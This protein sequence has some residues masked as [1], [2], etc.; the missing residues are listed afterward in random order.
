MKSTNRLLLTVLLLWLALPLMADGS[1]LTAPSGTSA[2]YVGLQGGV[3]FGV[4][5]FSAFGHDQTHAGFVGGIYGGYRFHPVVSLEAF[6]K[7][8][9]MA[10]TAQ[11]CCVDNHLWLG[12]DGNRYNVP[13]L[14]MDG[15]HYSDLHSQ[16]F[17]QHYG[18]QLNINLLGCFPTTRDSRWTLELS[19]LLAAVGTKA[20]VSNKADEATVIAGSQQW[21][22]GTGGN[23][24]VSYQASKHI[25]VGIYSGITYLTGK[26]FDGMPDCPHRA[27]YIW[28]SGVRLAF[29]MPTNAATERR[30]APLQNI[31]P[32]VEPAAERIAE[33]SLSPTVETPF[34]RVSASEAS[35]TSD[36]AVETPFMASPDTALAQ[37]THIKGVSTSE[38]TVAP[39]SDTTILSSPAASE[40]SGSEFSVQRSAHSI[41][42]TFNSTRI[43][44]S[45]LST[46]EAIRDT[47]LADP[48]LH[49]VVEGYCDAEGTTD[50][51]TNISTFR[52]QAVKDCLVSWG[53]SPERITVIGKGTDTQAPTPDHARR[54]D[55]KAPSNSPHR[56]STPCGQNTL[57]Y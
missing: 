55:I 8:G 14:D 16:V 31:E 5:T 19:P 36:N 50:A 20:T 54:A 39:A 42:F 49:I 32:Q 3:P 23:I 40:A 4:S 47:M 22:L 29:T 46:V 45:Q 30:T 56:G 52:A 33:E 21:H 6:A 17:T 41:Y 1:R 26:S 27:N 9:T 51:N 53:I 43:R 24:Q 11:A 37:E 25:N 48:T 44:Y 10:L 38:D 18:V 57:N 13:V 34:M 12:A 2:W 7:W 35:P 28:E 15:W